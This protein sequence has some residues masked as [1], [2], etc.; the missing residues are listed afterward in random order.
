MTELATHSPEP[1]LFRESTM[2]E[3]PPD[4]QLVV[5]PLSLLQSAVDRGLDADQLDKLLTLQERWERNQAEKAFNEAMT[6][7]QNEMPPVVRNCQNK[8]TGSMY[9]DLEGVQK[10]ARPIYSKYRFAPSFGEADCPL[11][12]HKR[13]ICDLRHDAG[14]TAHY[15][16]DLPVDGV[17]AKG[18]PIGNMNPVQ[19]CISTTS[20]GQRR[21]LCM[22]FNIT[23]VGEDDDG[24]GVTE[25]ITEKQAAVIHEWLVATATEERRFLN[26]AQCESVAALPAKKYEAAIDFFRRKSQK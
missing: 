19:G 23:V 22:M 25:K 6:D 4:R 8:Q 12:N 1:P 18:N 13:T 3:S 5:T 11:P 14:H 10:I 7:C 2:I 26:W 17:G 20:Y 15:H 24:Q 21:L 9:A 16:L